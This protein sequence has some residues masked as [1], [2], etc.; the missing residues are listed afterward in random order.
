MNGIQGLMG[1]GQGPMPGQAPQQPMPGM[2]QQQSAPTPGAMVSQ[3]SA[4]PFEQ[5]AQFYSNPRPQ[6][7]PLWAVISA[8]AEK[9]KQAKAMQMA[10]GQQV[11]AQNQQMQAQPPV[12]AEVVMSAEQTPGMEEQDTVMAALGG[13]MHSYAGGGAV[14]FTNGA[15][16]QGLPQENPEEDISDDPSLSF[17][18]RRI[19][20]AK[21]A[22]LARKQ[23]IGRSFAER[24][25]GFTTAAP[26]I[27]QTDT[28]DEALRLLK[29]IPPPTPMISPEA[30]ALMQR[31]GPRGMTSVSPQRPSGGGAVTRPQELPK[32]GLPSLMGPQIDPSLLM[33]REGQ[34]NIARALELSAK[35]TP[36]EIAAQAGI[37]KL[38]SA[39]ASSFE[40]ERKRREAVA[41]QRMQEAQARF[42]RPGYQDM[43]GIGNLLKGMKGAR[44]FYEGAVG[45]GAAAGD[46]Q[47]SK[48]AAL[49]AAQEKFDLS[50]KEMFDLSRLK[51]QV[52]MDQAKLVEARASGNAQRSV[53]AA[54]KLGESQQKL[55][56]FESGVVDKAAGRRLQEEGIKS[57]ERIAALNRQ[58]QAALRNLP[59]PEQQ[60]IENAIKSLMASNPGMAYHEAYDQVRG[61]GKGLK[62]RAEGLREKNEIARQKLLESDMTYFGLRNTYLNATDP[63]KKAE[64]LR[65]MRDIERLKGIVDEAAGSPDGGAVDR[66]NPLLK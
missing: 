11:M 45:A 62:E 40:E 35:Q 18:E 6:S 50:G 22:E 64:A 53:Q 63:A 12:A 57:A 7:P 9:Q 47:A 17:A 32:P 27:S 28:G 14:A 65:K 59:G 42:D 39:S 61:A 20:A 1:G 3:L 5:L 36:E 37:D 58:A 38:L 55:A 30:A 44:T 46:Y 66:T 41:Q 21:R 29:R 52:E 34:Q 8:I 48:E 56:E 25:P 19:R 15:G 24:Y 43:V 26:E 33:A 4:M 31:Q 2:M 10:Q 51:N 54:L 16:P 23:G 49:R 60:M 13:M